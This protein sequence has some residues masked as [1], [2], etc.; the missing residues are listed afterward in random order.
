MRE[1]HQDHVH[2]ARLLD[3]MD[4][5]L[6]LLSNDG[7]P[8]L[9]LMTDIVNYIQHYPDLVHHPKEDQVYKVFRECSDKWDDE[10]DALINDHQNMPIATLDFFRL[11][12]GAANGSAIITRDELIERVETFIKLQRKHINKE[13]DKI[14]PMIEKT[15]SEED[16]ANIE[17][18][19]VH[20][21]DPLFG[22]NVEDCYKN[23]YQSI[24]S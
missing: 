12:E 22:T 4:Q 7:D 15:L 24:N 23:L 11:L 13:E 19:L 2:L 20:R 18:N 16:W 21:A 1:L 8:D 9:Y 17:K 14:F 10:V 3:I 5:Q 6:E